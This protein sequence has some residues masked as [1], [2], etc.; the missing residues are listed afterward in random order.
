MPNFVTRDRVILFGQPNGLFTGIEP[1]SVDRHG[2]DS[3]TD[4]TVPGRAVLAGRDDFG[5]PRTK[6]EYD[7]APSGL[8]DFTVTF[9]KQ[10]AQ[11]QVLDTMRRENGRFGLWEF[12]I[13]AGRLNNYAN[14]LLNG[15][16]DYYSR[17]KI[18]GMTDDAGSAKDY[19]G[20]PGTKSFPISAARLI[21]LRPPV[22]S[23]LT[24]S[25]IVDINGITG[26]SDLDPNRDIPGYPG[27]DKL[28]FAV[29]DA[30]TGVAANVLWTI[31]G[32]STWTAFGAD[33]FAADKHIKAV[34]A[35]FMTPTQYRLVVLRLT[36][37]AA[38]PPQIAYADI[39]VGDEGTSPTWTA[40]ALGATNNQTGEALFW[41][42]QLFNRL[43][44]AAAGDIYVSTNQG[45]ST[46]IVYTGA[47][48][49]N[50]F[51][52]DIDLNVWA[53]GASNTILRESVDNRGTFT[54]K[55]GPSGGGAFTAIAIADDG[56]IFAGNATSI[57]KS[58][59][60]AA[61]TGGWSLLR[62]FGANESVVGIQCVGGDSQILRAVVTNTSSPE[63]DVWYSLDG[64]NTWTEVANLTNSGY[65]AVYFS[66]VN[67]NLA[68]IVGEDVSTVGTIHRLG[69]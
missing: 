60:D 3:M 20:E 46:T 52:I 10:A 50:A 2:R 13:P 29:C 48:A 14:W 22:L 9:D 56:T 7:E 23:A 33:P 57:Y 37:E 40:V 69:N 53:V 67:D 41:P 44:A 43:Y 63:G 1:L 16:L 66:T 58:N 38:L 30:D 35:Q 32:G 21:T 51:A 31:T 61:S 59:N 45:Q 25:E 34:Q 47:N 5:R 6:L 42:P 27:P 15:R 11:D 26:F 18:T 39:T 68:F 4:N 24:T 8:L 19:S 49:I 54:T 28:L 64:G 55:V 17:C 12:Y 65:N 36:G 62:N